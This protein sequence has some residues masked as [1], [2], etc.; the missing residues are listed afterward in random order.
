[1]P[2]WSGFWNTVY[3]DG[4]ASIGQDGYRR[5]LR[6]A[7]KNARNPYN[8]VISA[9]VQGV[10][11]AVGT[12]TRIAVQD[13]RDPTSLG[14]VRPY[15]TRTVINRAITRSSTDMTTDEMKVRTDLYNQKW[16]NPNNPLGKV[17][18]PDKSGNGGG[19]QRGL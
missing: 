16:Y 12:Q 1:M 11:S 14:G 19:G 18:P 6:T 17:F 13:T 8:R 7:M 2:S 9:L 5:R 4:Y 10:G 3:G 15:E